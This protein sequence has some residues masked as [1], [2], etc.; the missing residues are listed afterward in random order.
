MIFKY[1]FVHADPH[2]GNIFVR[3]KEDQEN[4]KHKDYDIV[5]LDHGI[6]RELSPEVLK[7]YSKLWTGIITRDTE[8]IK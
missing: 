7:N 3:P 5:L 8:T 1:G 6:Y 4:K 2:P